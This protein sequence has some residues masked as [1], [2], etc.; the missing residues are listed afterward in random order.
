MKTQPTQTTKLDPSESGKKKFSFQLLIVFI[1]FALMIIVGG[2]FYY[3][4]ESISIKNTK[5]EELEA[6]AELKDG[7]IHNWLDERFSDATFF[8]KNAAFASQVIK[9]TEDTGNNKIREGILHQLAII[10]AN[11][12]YEGVFILLHDQKEIIGLHDQKLSSPT[13]SDMQVKDT[14]HNVTMTDF[15]INQQTGKINLDFNVPYYKSDTSRCWSA[16]LIFRVNPDLNLYPMIQ[17]WPTPSKSSETLLV[18]RE[19]NEV[20]YLNDL[21]H[22]NNS[23]LKLRFSINDKELPAAMAARGQEGIVEG[24]DYRGISVLADIKKVQGAPWFMITKTDQDEIYAELNYR[25]LIIAIFIVLGIILTGVIILMIWRNTLIF[26]LR[27][28]HEKDIILHEI[29]RKAKSTSLQLDAIFLNIPDI[30]W[31]KDVG[32]KIINVNPAFERAFNVISG[33]ARGKTD[34]DLWPQEI[35]VNYA[36]DDIN[37]VKTGKQKRLTE[38]YHDPEG[39]LRWVDT[40]KSPMFDDTG[41]IAGTIGIARD[42]TEIIRKEEKIKHLNR[43]YALLSEIN[44]TIVRTHDKEV[45]FT[46]VCRIAIEY[47]QFNIAFIGKLNSSDEKI[48]V[49]ASSI[50]DL[51]KPEKAVEL[52][53]IEPV[54]SSEERKMIEAGN[55]YVCNS[56]L[57]SGGSVITLKGAERIEFLS[58]GIFPIMF[59]NKSD[60]FFALFSEKIEYFTAEDIRLLAELTSDISFSLN[61]IDLE[62]KQMVA[63]QR[64]KRVFENASLGMSLTAIDGKLLMVNKALAEMLG[65]SVIELTGKYFGDITH[66]D[67]IEASKNLVNSFLIKKGFQSTPL[68]KRYIRKDGSII[69]SEISSS[70]VLDD[71]SKP[72]YFIT[73]MLNISERRK[74]VEEIKKLNQELELRV[75]ERTTELLAYT[76]ELEAFSYSISHDLSAPLRSINGFSNALNEDYFELLDEK[77][78]DYLNR[79]GSGVERMSRL[80][81]D[82][83]S[84]SLITRQE[85]HFEM[86]DASEMVR[87]ISSAYKTNNEVEFKIKDRIIVDGDKGLIRIALENLIGNAIKYSAKAKKPV[88]KFD[89]VT[90]KGMQFLTIK[91][92]GVGFDMTYVNK[93]FIPFQRLH[94]DVDFK[95]SGI[96]LALVQRIINKHGGEIWAESETGKGATFTFRFFSPKNNAV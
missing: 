69:W 90:L 31:L 27:K 35:A 64:F 38:S 66:P 58:Y 65:Y 2:Y 59:D 93:L 30:A 89:A 5:H 41:T 82:M 50:P 86:V 7:Q 68:Q 21:R 14:V 87:E 46:E 12:D 57:K 32:G 76:R 8:L 26:N 80:I 3:F 92:N 74:A 62:K 24:T 9:L 61:L 73:Q 11:H 33:E 6:I 49:L 70:L 22:K 54:L 34:F 84:L 45:L 67:D 88:V 52:N 4:Y 96:G 29:E 78:K 17:K 39:N 79:I 40:I 1:A 43:I 85:T 60:F 53:D 13:Y 55:S 23:A 42:I 18:R 10:K 71:D 91:D 47:G 75:A 63:E 15:F 20:V 81:E 83:L 36:N 25:F 48:K 72:S 19:G 94:T 51:N 37:V 28:M 56:T 16:L 77:G 95:G 44:Q